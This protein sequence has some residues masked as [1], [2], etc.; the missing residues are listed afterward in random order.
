MR[1]KTE[2]EN[3]VQFLEREI[4]LGKKPIAFIYSRNRKLEN[5]KFPGI[6]PKKGHIKLL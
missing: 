2:I 5:T 1:R 4:D 3:L 6:Y